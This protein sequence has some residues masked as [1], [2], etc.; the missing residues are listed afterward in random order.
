MEYVAIHTH[1]ATKIF[2]ITVAHVP[3]CRQ[4]VLIVNPIL[5]Q[6]PVGGV[7]VIHCILWGIL[8]TMPIKLIAFFLFLKNADWLQKGY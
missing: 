2:C 7:F 5:H 8:Y 4:I 3:Q 1:E 6:D